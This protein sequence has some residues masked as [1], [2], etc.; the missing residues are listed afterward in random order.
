M[1]QT[2]PCGDDRQ[3]ASVGALLLA[4]DW[5]VRPV[6]M[7]AAYSSNSMEQS[8][9]SCSAGKPT[10]S[11]CQVWLMGDPRRSKNS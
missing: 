6:S 9:L 2:D 7:S 8:S 4:S 3:G 5:A 11:S 10:R 1:D